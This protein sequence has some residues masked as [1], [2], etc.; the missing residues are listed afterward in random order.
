MSEHSNLEYLGRPS[1][2]S[3]VFTARGAGPLKGQQFAAYRCED[4]GEHFV[5]ESLDADLRMISKPHGPDGVYREGTILSINF[6]TGCVKVFLKRDLPI[7]VFDEVKRGCVD[8]PFIFQQ[9][10]VAEAIAKELVGRN[11]ALPVQE[12]HVQI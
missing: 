3:H 8:N 12:T 5:R 1:R 6:L 9:Y 4:T 11:Y 10:P 2:Y 7:R